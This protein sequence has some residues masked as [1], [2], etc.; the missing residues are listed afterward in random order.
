M[1]RA[2]VQ[3]W[4][5][6]LEYWDE[7][8]PSLVSIFQVFFDDLYREFPLGWLRSVGPPYFI[9]VLDRGVKLINDLLDWMSEF[10]TVMPALIAANIVIDLFR[11][12]PKLRQ[13]VMTLDEVVKVPVR[14][15][16]ELGIRKYQ[17]A[18]PRDFVLAD[19]VTRFEKLLGGIRTGRLSR[20]LK[21]LLGSVFGRV[22]KLGLI[23]LRWGQMF[24]YVLLL[25]RYLSMLEDPKSTDLFFRSKLF[26]QHKRKRVRE[27]IRRR[28]GGVKP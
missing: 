17:E 10:L 27:R 28:I 23:A 7:R 16:V 1:K 13:R 24:G 6:F 3:A 4:R 12:D 26:N 8:I 14:V 25:Y 18:P 5:S 21:A 9:W 22:F 19:R 2:L 15:L 11:P 20:M